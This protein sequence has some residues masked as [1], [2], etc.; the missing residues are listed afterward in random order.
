ML[1]SMHHVSVY[2]SYT[3]RLSDAM[4]LV[5]LLRA[6]SVAAGGGLAAIEAE[7]QV[8]CAPSAE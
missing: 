1:R 7:A 3:E 2:S 8:R 6:R 4:A 5:E